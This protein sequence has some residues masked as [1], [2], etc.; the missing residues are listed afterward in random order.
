MRACRRRLCRDPSVTL[1]SINLQSHGAVLVLGRKLR[2][3][4]LSHNVATS[5]QSCEGSQVSVLLTS[6]LHEVHVR[7]CVA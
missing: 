2:E 3:L 1:H 5:R 4:G 6:A 7:C